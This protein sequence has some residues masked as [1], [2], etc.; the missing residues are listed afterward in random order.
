MFIIQKGEVILFEERT[1]KK[2]KV[3]R[4]GD[5]FG[6]VGFF[7]GCQRTCSISS[8]GF[9]RLYKIKREMILDVI[10]DNKK[11]LVSPLE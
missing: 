7:T 9:C 10:K 11:E 8:L 3:L 1:Q 6:E 2:I 4:K 5:S